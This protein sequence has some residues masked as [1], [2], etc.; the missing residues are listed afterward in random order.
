MCI[1][2]CGDGEAEWGSILLEA[3]CQVAGRYQGKG[4]R[5]SERRSRAGYTKRTQ[6]M[7][8]SGS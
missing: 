8:E 6:V 5:E 7:E 4:K 3:W 2:A 1:S